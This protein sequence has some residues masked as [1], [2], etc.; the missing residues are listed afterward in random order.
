[1]RVKVTIF[2]WHLPCPL[3]GVKWSKREPEKCASAAFL[4]HIYKSAQCVLHFG[5]YSMI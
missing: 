1:M 2:Q 4:N 3:G 5:S